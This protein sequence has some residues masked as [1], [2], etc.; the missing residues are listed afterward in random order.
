MKKILKLMLAVLMIVSF[1]ACSGETSTDEQKEV[2]ESFFNYVAEC[3]FDKLDDIA[4]SDVVDS[5][6]LDSMEASLSAYNDPDTYGQVFID[7][8]EDF[9]KAVF[10]KLFTD[11]KIGDIDVDGDTSTVKVTGKYTDYSTISLDTSI[12]TELQN[13][14]IN[15]NKDELANIYREQG[16]TAYQI[17]VFDNIAPQ[18]YE[19][20]KAALD[21]AE[22]TD[23]TATFTLEKKDDKWI[24]TS[25]TD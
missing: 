10:E 4:E 3:E 8:T 1:T 7:E 5:F 9:K 12:I 15:E 16:A 14:Y 11:I 25:I 19:Q 20:M 21:E 6:G 22:S 13:N 18:Y 2:V 17:K 23:L 24:I